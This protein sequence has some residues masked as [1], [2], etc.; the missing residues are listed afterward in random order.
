M[1]W[2]IIPARKGS[3]GFPGKNRL[4]FNHTASIVPDYLR[5]KT[6]ITS[7]DEEIIEQAKNFDFRIHF[8]ANHLCTDEANIK[9]VL[10]DVVN[11]FNIFEKDIVSMVYLPYPQRTWQDVCNAYV[12]LK[13]SYAKSLLCREELDPDEIHPYRYF[14]DNENGTGSQVVTHDLYRRQD[15][16]KVFKANHFIFMSYADE[17]KKLNKNLWNSDT[18]FYPVRKPIDIDNKED[19]EKFFRITHNYDTIRSIG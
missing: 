12:F 4:L 5:E 2:I 13:N 1:Q 6:I 19:F 7:D 9:D 8:R 15:Y 18:V 14:Y 10:L 3:K 17:I 16:P 11:N